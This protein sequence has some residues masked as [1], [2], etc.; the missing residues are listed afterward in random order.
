M[1]LK[2][3][4]VA[5]PAAFL[6]L[7]GGAANARKTINEEGPTLRSLK[8]DT[9]WSTLRDDGSASATILPYQAA[10]MNTCLM[11]VGR[12]AELARAPTKMETS[13]TRPGRKVRTPR[14]T[15]TSGPETPA[16]TKVPVAAERTRAPQNGYRLALLG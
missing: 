6:I 9:S 5:A 8:R 14:N 13:R 4:F 15:F 11:G 7:G 12:A 2:Q 10:H 16:N 3:L 1:A